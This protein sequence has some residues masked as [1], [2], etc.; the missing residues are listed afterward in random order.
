M[1]KDKIWVVKRVLGN[2]TTSNNIDPVHGCHQNLQQHVDILKNVN[3]D[4]WDTREK[5][6]DLAEKT[7]L[8]AGFEYIIENI[9]TFIDNIDILK[10]KWV[11]FTDD[12]DWVENNSHKVLLE[13]IQNNQDL[14]CIIWPH[15]RYHSLTNIITGNKEIDPQYTPVPRLQT[16]HCL[17]KLNDKFINTWKPELDIKDKIQHWNLNDYI[18]ASPEQNLN[19]INIPKY[20]SLWNNSPI[21]FSWRYHHPDMFSVEERDKLSVRIANYA[22]FLPERS[23]YLIKHNIGTSYINYIHAQQQFFKP[24]IDRGASEYLNTESRI[25]KVNYSG[26]NAFTEYLNIEKI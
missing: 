19:I 20:L 14:D 18:F 12:D 24:R 10:N 21:S 8:H 7:L 15:V 16:N 5:I 13:A 17:I 9:E 2:Y 22:L 26:N 4:Y 3:I 11:F 6:I 1:K 23:E 25:F